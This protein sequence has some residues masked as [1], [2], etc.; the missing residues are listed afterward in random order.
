M[1][2]ARAAVRSRMRLPRRRGEGGQGLAEYALVAGLVAGF[3][4]ALLALA[5]QALAAVDRAIEVMLN[6]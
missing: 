3:A 4:A 2:R 6:A 1:T 5:G